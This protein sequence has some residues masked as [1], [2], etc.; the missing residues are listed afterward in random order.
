MTSRVNGFSLQNRTLTS[1]VANNPKNTMDWKRVAAVA[2]SIAIA[3]VGSSYYLYRGI[4]MLKYSDWYC[5]QGP[6]SKMCPDLMNFIEKSCKKPGLD[7][8]DCNF[9][10]IIL[11]S[12]YAK[13]L[14]SPA[15]CKPLLI[16][17]EKIFPIF[18]DPALYCLKQPISE[19]C[20]DVMQLLETACKTA[21]RCIKKPCEIIKDSL[22]R[23]YQFRRYCISDID[24][25]SLNN[26][27]ANFASS[28]KEFICADVNIFPS[29][30]RKKT[31]IDSA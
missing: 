14:S 23:T 24:C 2:A 29:F 20:P 7:L 31:V 17:A 21:S 1:S 27:V 22:I 19:I 5:N 3:M 16:S 25:A 30:G 6:V 4:S 26:E 12:N 11:K 10:K 15:V 8:A 28:Y 13:I 18:E 9:W